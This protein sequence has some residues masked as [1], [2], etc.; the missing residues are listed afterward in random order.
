MADTTYGT[1][2]GSVGT[3]YIKAG[4]A[5]TS[6]GVCCVNYFASTD[7]NEIDADWGEVCGFWQPD[8]GMPIDVRSWKMTGCN[9][10][11]AS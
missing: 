11:F 6:D 5:F 4:S 7:C 9:P 1:L 10:E 8:K 2:F 3:N